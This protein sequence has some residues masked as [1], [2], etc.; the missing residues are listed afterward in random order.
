MSIPVVRPV[1][2]KLQL[3]EIRRNA[4]EDDHYVIAPTHAIYK[5]DRICGYWSIDGMPTVHLWHDSQRI[6]ARDS[7][8]LS[9]SL[10]QNIIN[11]GHSRFQILCSSE[12]P[13]FPHVEKLGFVPVFQSNLLFK[14][15]K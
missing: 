7:L 9:E 8:Y 2:D 3:A 14:E 15:I 10:N 11:R 5:D 6:N 1:S 12:S 4:A 13:Y